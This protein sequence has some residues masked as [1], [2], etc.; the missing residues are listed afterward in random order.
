MK[1]RLYAVNT[2]NGNIIK[3]YRDMKERQI[4]AIDVGSSNVVIAVGAV[5]DDGR[6]NIQGIVSEPIEGIDAGRVENIA[7]AGSAVKAAKQRIEQELNIKITEAYAGLSGDFVRCVQVTDY[8]YVQDDSS[9]QITERDLEDLDR[10][11]RSVKLPDDREE[12]LSMEAVRYTIDD[13]VVDV[14]VGAYGHKLNATYNFILSDRSMRD[15]LNQCLMNQGIKV[16]EFAPNALISHLAVA[17]DEDIEEGVVI[18]DLGGGVTDVSVL[19]RGKVRHI[20]SIPIGADSIN[21]DIRAYGI[22]ANYVEN[23][24]RRYGSALTDMATDDKIVFPVRRGVPKSILRRNLATIIEAR[25]KEIAEWV[26]R[27]IKEAGCG[28]KF[29]PILLITGGG[30]EMQ[31]IET[32]FSRELGI[33]EVRAVYPEY[34]FTENMT[35]VITTSAYATVASLLLFGAERGACAVAGGVRV[36]PVVEPEVKPQRHTIRVTTPMPEP[37]PEPEPKPDVVVKPESQPAPESQPE[38][39]IF[40]P[41]DN[42]GKKKGGKRRGGFLSGLDKWMTNIGNQFVGNN[43]ESEF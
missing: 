25:L 7:L 5:E 39:D 15:R 36:A 40:D 23:L 16:K 3:Q 11:M 28:P 38:T 9:N 34:G 32:L 14:P 13:K 22:P 26:R 31:N 42:A 8:V 41:G 29:S 1:V 33:D 35:D 43:D 12:I 2:H 6:V 37:Q 20:A 10:R 4:V 30:A 18:V 24:K 21:N 17:T 19:M 27:E